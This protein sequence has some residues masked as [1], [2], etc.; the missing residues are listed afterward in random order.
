MF[1]LICVE[2]VYLIMAGEYNLPL[3]YLFI[4]QLIVLK[5]K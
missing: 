2:K 3:A 4:I 1:A 5:I